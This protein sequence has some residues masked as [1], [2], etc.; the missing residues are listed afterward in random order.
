MWGWSVL[1]VDVAFSH[2]LIHVLVGMAG[3][4]SLCN[5]NFLLLFSTFMVPLV[6]VVISVFSAFTS[7]MTRAEHRKGVHADQHRC[8]P[9]FHPAV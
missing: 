4:A 6:M 8:L 3:I 7:S 1:S 5:I 2:V 9:L